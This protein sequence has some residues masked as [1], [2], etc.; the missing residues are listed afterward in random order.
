MFTPFGKNLKESDRI[1]AL[2]I[3]T[4]ISVTFNLKIFANFLRVYISTGCRIFRTICLLNLELSATYAFR[5]L[6]SNFC[7]NMIFEVLM[8]PKLEI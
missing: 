3:F 4:L 5:K 8:P 6:C 7:E 2:Y 1:V